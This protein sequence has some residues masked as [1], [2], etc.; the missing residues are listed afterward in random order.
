MLLRPV[1]YMQWLPYNTWQV[2]YIAWRWIM[3]CYFCTWLILSGTKFN[4]TPHI[5]ST[6]LEFMTWVLYL[7]V[8]AVSCTVKFNIHMYPHV[9]GNDNVNTDVEQ[10]KR[11]DV[12]I[13]N[14]AAD[15]D[16]VDVYADWRI[17]SVAWYQKIHWILYSISLPIEIGISVLYWFQLYNPFENN[18][19][20]GLNFNTHFAP[21]VIAVADMWLSGITLNIYHVYMVYLFGVV[22]SNQCAVGGV[23]QFANEYNYS[24]LYYGCIPYFV[25]YLISLPRRW[26]SSK[27]RQLIY[28]E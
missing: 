22:Y 12:E 26:L 16:D 3:A 7:I 19:I 4:D 15:H 24:T 27:T 5:V 25:L 2:I 13:G 17:D 14:T 9:R 11:K 28:T 20:S 23:D 1:F 21:A 18:S 10:T 6:K 8:S